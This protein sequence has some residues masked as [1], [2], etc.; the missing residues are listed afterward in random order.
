VRRLALLWGLGA[1]LVLSG[2]LGAFAD[3]VSGLFGLHTAAERAVSVPAI[4]VFCLSTPFAG[5]LII[6]TEYFQST[7][8]TAWSGLVTAL[9]NFL[10]LL[11]CTLLFGLLRPADFWWVFPVCEAA[12]LLGAVAARRFLP[13]KRMAIVPAFSACMDHSNH[14]LGRVL[15]DLE[16]FCEDQRIPRKTALQLQLAVEE[17]CLVTME[18]AFTGKPDEYIQIT[19]ARESSGDY[20]LCI[21]N[22]APRFNPFAMEMGRLQ[23]DR[24]EKLMDSMGVLLV[25]ERAKSM[26]YRHYDGFNVLLVV[27]GEQG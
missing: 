7:F 26:H 13:W 11:P 6:L 15:S 4:R 19:L 12:S 22:S 2:L 25:R 5:I 24:E 18:Q 14:D 21:R 9:R 3:T 17:L 20:T 16:A 23:R 1:G 10:L 27:F 8:Q